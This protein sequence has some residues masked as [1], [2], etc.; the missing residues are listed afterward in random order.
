MLFTAFFSFLITITPPSDF[1]CGGSELHASIYNSLRETQQVFQDIENLEEDSFT[2][3]EWRDYELKI[4]I[5]KYGG[6]SFADRF[7]KWSYLNEEI[8]DLE[9]PSFSRQY[10]TGKV[11]T[12]RCKLP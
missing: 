6:M 3:L 10:P 1:V 2:L 11:V 9:H 8:L 4:P 7:W 12:Y 5:T